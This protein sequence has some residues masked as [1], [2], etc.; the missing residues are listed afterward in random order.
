MLLF[1]AHIL[2]RNISE[3]VSGRQTNNTAEIQA[4]ERA[5]RQAKQNGIKNSYF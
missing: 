1:V 4:A 5:I 2:T 3:P